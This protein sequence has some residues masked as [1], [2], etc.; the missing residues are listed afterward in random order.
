MRALTPANCS[1]VQLI[2]ASLSSV[3]VYQV[4]SFFVVFVTIAHWPSLD[5]DQPH[6]CSLT[7]KDT[8]HVKHHILKEIYSVQLLSTESRVIS[9]NQFL[10]Y[11]SINSNLLQSVMRLKSATCLLLARCCRKC[12]VPAASANTSSVYNCRSFLMT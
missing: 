4:N 5:E 10:L 1:K 12:I 3:C 8:Q 11:R 7:K 2:L 9:P 6:H